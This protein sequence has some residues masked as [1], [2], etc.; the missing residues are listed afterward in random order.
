MDYYVSRKKNPGPVISFSYQNPDLENAPKK[1]KATKKTAAYKEFGRFWTPSLDSVSDFDSGVM[2]GACSA[3]NKASNNRFNWHKE[4]GSRLLRERQ[5]LRKLK[6]PRSALGESN[7][8]NCG[9]GD[10]RLMGDDKASR[11]LARQLPNDGHLRRSVK[12]RT[13]DHPRGVRMLAR[14]RSAIGP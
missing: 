9:T 14:L 3:D 13:D 2:I 8:Y 1:N 12:R 7:L 4:N 5:R 6:R 10:H 11:H